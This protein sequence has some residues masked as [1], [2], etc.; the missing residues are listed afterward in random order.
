MA[1]RGRKAILRDLSRLFADQTLLRC[2]PWPSVALRGPPWTKSCSSWP[3]VDRKQLF[4]ALRGQKAV[5]RDPSRPFASLRGS[6]SVE[7]YS[8]ALC[9]PPWTKSSSS[10]PF[11]NRKQFFASLRGSNSVEMYSLALR[12]KKQFSA[13]PVKEKILPIQRPFQ[14]GARFSENARGPSTASSLPSISS[15]AGYAPRNASSKLP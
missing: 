15:A 12:A 14:T 9:G 8:V 2:T 4:M 13:A 3:F 7:L 10:W 1:L 5:F 6:N 11:V